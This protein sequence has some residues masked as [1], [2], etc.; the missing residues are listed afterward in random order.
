MTLN[1]IITICSLILL[2]YIFDITAPKTKIPSV[3]LLLILGWVAGEAVYYLDISVPNLEP[4]LPILG[5]VGLILIVLE[6]SMELEFNKTKVTVLKRSFL[7]ALISL[8]VLTA[9]MAWALNYYMGY[10]WKVA[11]I[12]S[13]PLFII[14]SAI[15]IPSVQHISAPK[16]EFVTYESSLSDILGVIFFNFFVLNEIIG[17][18]EIGLFFYEILL[19]MVIS[20]VASV[21]LAFMLSKIKHNIKFAPIILSIIIIYALSKIYHLPALIFILLFGLFLS[22]LDELKRFKWI[23]KLK[24]DVLDREVGKF[25]EITS[26]ATFLVRSLFFL[27]FGFL[28][29]AK[30]LIEKDSLIIALL[31][32]IAIFVLRWIQLKLFKI[33]LYPLLFI[34]PRGLITILLYLSIPEQYHI[35]TINKPLIIQIIVITAFIMMVGLII[36]KTPQNTY[37]KQAFKDKAKQLISFEKASVRRRLNR[38]R[39]KE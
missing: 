28:I 2:A 20:F 3:I 17:W 25:H 34:A 15:A 30:S 23:E 29:D 1:I 10:P 33:N 4:V 8:G 13:I 27:L 22:N 35:T 36:T 26:E 5:T 39:Q 38:I 7:I 11:I 21:G 12:N 19:M 18:K 9:L 6:G 14:S 24:P 32:S 16:K 37:S 31:V